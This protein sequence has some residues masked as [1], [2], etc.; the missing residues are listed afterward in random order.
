MCRHADQDPRRSQLCCGLS[1]GQLHQVVESV[2][3]VSI[4]GGQVI[5][6]QDEAGDSLFVVA[7]GR[8]MIGVSQGNG[9]ERLFD[10]LGVGDHFGEM[11]M[12]TGGRRDVTV[13]AVIDSDLL[14]LKHH[15]FQQLLLTVPGSP[16][17][18]AGRSATACAAKR[19]LGGNSTRCTARRARPIITQR[20]ARSP[21]QHSTNE[22]S[23]SLNFRGHIRI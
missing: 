9:Q 1:I 3:R 13:T 10:Y 4:R 19:M 15:A 5:F 18:F 21:H 8:V 14:E 7:S 2:R 23:G 22:G 17:T 12:L 20:S 11:A 16:P 6:R